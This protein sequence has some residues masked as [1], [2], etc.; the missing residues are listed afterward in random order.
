MEVR[1]KELENVGQVKFSVFVPQYS[2]S[3]LISIYIPIYS[4]MLL[5]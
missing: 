1:N 4:S 2:V 3:L 5:F